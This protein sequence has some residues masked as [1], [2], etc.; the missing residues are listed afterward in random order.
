MARR[1][2]ARALTALGLDFA[3]GTDSFSVAGDQAR[4]HLSGFPLLRNVSI[5]MEGGDK[6]LANRFHAVL[7]RRMARTPAE[8]TP[9]A[10]SLLLVATAMLVAPLALMAQR[11]PE[12]VRILTDLLP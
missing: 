1:H 6:D 3:A 10:V 2:V 8:P 4:I 11:V 12:I 9:M 5:R 7:S